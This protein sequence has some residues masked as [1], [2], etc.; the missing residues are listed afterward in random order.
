MGGAL[1][2]TA[3]GGDLIGWSLAGSVAMVFPKSK[4]ASYG[5]ALA[6]AQQAQRYG[7]QEI[8]GALMHFAGFG[9]DRHQ[10]ALALSVLDYLKGVKGLQVFGGG[11]MLLEPHRVA[12][13][14]DCFL[15]ACGC[16][17]SRAHCVVVVDEP[18]VVAIGGGVREPV[19]R[20]IDVPRLDGIDDWLARRPAWTE[21]KRLSFPCRHLLHRNFRFQPDHPASREAQIQAAAVREGCDWC[22][23]LNASIL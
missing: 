5:P 23:N 16:D 19:A 10:A 8:G 9:R 15:K 13:V 17:D 11:Q 14:L 18:T 3:T 2:P 21:P 20:P 12:A 6:L 7:E 1:Q 22:P 4:S